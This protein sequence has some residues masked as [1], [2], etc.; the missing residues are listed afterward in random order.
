ME[1]SQ[2]MSNAAPKKPLSKKTILGAIGALIVLVIGY[3]YFKKK[4][5]ATTADTAASNT[6][7][8]ATSTDKGSTAGGNVTVGK[9]DLVISGTTLSAVWTDTSSIFYNKYSVSA[10]VEIVNPPSTG[11]LVIKI[12]NKVVQ[13]NPLPMVDGGFGPNKAFFVSFE[14]ADNMQ[15]TISANIGTAITKSV[16]Y[17]SP[18]AI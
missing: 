17:I 5:T 16:T 7:D 18:A 13:S 4:S 14:L 15:H 6:S 12:D 10:T 3:L 9:T 8:K 1:N 11:T 2:N